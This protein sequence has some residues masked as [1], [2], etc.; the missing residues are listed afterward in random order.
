VLQGG[1]YTAEHGVVVR[2]LS[3]SGPGAW[4]PYEQP[5]GWRGGTTTTVRVRGGKGTLR[6]VT[7]TNRSMLLWYEPDGRPWW[8]DGLGLPGSELVAAVEALSI[9]GGQLTARP[10]PGLET[11]VPLPRFPGPDQVT[12]HF[13]AT[14]AP[15]G[16]GPATSWNLQVSHGNAAFVP[17]PGARRV[18]VDGVVA[19]WTSVGATP[20]RGELTW[21]DARGRLFTI[22][23]AITETTALAAARSLAPLRP[24][25]PR[26]VAL[27]EDG[28]A[29]ASPS[30]TAAVRH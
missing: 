8:A 20:G 22:T 21:T 23:G 18:D 16:G 28:A 25:D 2:N 11:V 30:S 1:W 12:E 3:V 4:D 15:R 6:Q 17:Q 5:N 13:L 27:A 29:V 19:W 7:E 14:F 10:L 24:D 26:L 9:S